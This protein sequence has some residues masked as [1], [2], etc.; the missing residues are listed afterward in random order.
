[1]KNINKTQIDDMIVK[2]KKKTIML[3]SCIATTVVVVFCL[4]FVTFF[5]IV[6]IPSL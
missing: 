3:I 4:V 2:D 6:Y 1:M 5:A